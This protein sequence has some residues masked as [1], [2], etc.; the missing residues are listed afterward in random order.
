MNPHGNNTD[1][2][3]PSSDPQTPRILANVSDIELEIADIAQFL[4]TWPDMTDTLKS[5]LLDSWNRIPSLRGTRKT[6]ELCNESDVR[7][8]LA[9]RADDW[10]RHCGFLEN[11][12]PPSI[13]S[14][15]SRATSPAD[16]TR[17]K[18][19]SGSGSQAEGANVRPEM[20][21]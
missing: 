21:V 17:S 10:V 18:G 3:S 8:L 7:P 19:G 1:L 2:Y 20:T 15:P 13:S 16:S 12:R 9:D 5:E 11:R 14:Q 6:W 4:S